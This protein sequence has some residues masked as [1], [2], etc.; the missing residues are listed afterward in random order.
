MEMYVTML[1]LSRA[2]NRRR[3]R[4]RC[5]WGGGWCVLPLRTALRTT[6][7]IAHQTEHLSQT[8]CMTLCTAP[9]S[10]RRTNST[11][12]K[13]SSGRAGRNRLSQR[14]APALR[15]WTGVPCILDRNARA[16]WGET[17]VTAVD[18]MVMTLAP[19]VMTSLALMVGWSQ[20][21]TTKILA[22]KALH[23]ASVVVV[24][25]QRVR[26]VPGD[27]GIGGSSLLI[28]NHT[29]TCKSIAYVSFYRASVFVGLEVKVSVIDVVSLLP[30]SL[31]QTGIQNHG[32]TWKSSLV[33]RFTCVFV[34]VSTCISRL[35]LLSLAK[36]GI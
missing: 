4:G 36:T 3:C 21:M 33:C 34:F 28:Q 35:C 19:M 24:W 20:T 5:N 23:L 2:C 15:D 32:E 10:G 8:T 30:N 9:P 7:W 6:P 31:E 17:A 25:R 18:W 13:K 26:S 11:Y 14:V 22:L 1:H 16:S 12:L 29:E 27:N